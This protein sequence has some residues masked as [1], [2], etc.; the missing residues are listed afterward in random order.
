M[1][2]L[3]HSYENLKLR[4]TLPSNNFKIY[5]MNSNLHTSRHVLNPAD[6]LLKSLCPSIQ[7][8]TCMKQLKNGEKAILI[9][10]DTGELYEILSTHLFNFP[11]RPDS[12]NNHFML[13]VF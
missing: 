9:K 6:Y 13:C 12:F 5:V 3:E 8:S 10:F 7:L 4:S 2:I 11:F 1:K